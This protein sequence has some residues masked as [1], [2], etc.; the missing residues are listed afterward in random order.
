MK[1]LIRRLWHWREEQFLVRFW[2]AFILLLP[3]ALVLRWL[4]S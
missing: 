1:D 3:L 4:A 2:A